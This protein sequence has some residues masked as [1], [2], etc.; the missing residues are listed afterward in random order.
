MQFIGVIFAIELQYFKKIIMKRILLLLVSVFSLG[1][2]FGQVYEHNFGSTAISAHPYNITPSSIATNLTG[3]S[4][5]NSTGSWTSYAGASGQAIS[6]GN[7]AGSPTVTLTFDVDP[8]FQLDLTSFDFWR[9]RSNSGAQNWS[10]AI[11]G[12]GVGSGSVPTSG[13]SIGVTSVT[14]FTGLTGTVTIV[15]SLSGASGSGTFRLDDFTLNGSVTSLS[16]DTELNFSSATYSES[17]NGTSVDLCVDITN[18]SVTPT[19]ANVVLTTANSPHLTAYT[20][21]G[22]TFP[23]SSSAQQCVTVSILDNT[24]CSDAT[25]YT[26]ELQSVSGGTNASAGSVDETILSVSDDDGSS[27]QIVFQGFETSGDTWNYTN[28]GGG[29]SSTNSGTPNNDRRK[30]GARSF[31]R[32][33]GAATITFDNGGSGVDIST[34]TNVVVDIWSAGISGN[35]SNGMDNNDDIEV[36]VSQTAT[37]G[38]TP[39]IT[40]DGTSNLKYGMS[41]TGV[42]STTAG[43]PISYNYPSGGTKSGNDAKS[44]LKVNIPDAWNT[45]FVKIVT[46]SNSSNEIWCI[47]DVKLTGDICLVA[48][49][50]INVKGNATDIAD[51]DVTPDAADD[52]DFG[53]VLITGGTNP[54][55]FTIQ[56]TGTAPLT[57]TSAVSSNNTDFALTAFTPGVVLAGNST[58]FTV[59]FD[60]TT[61]GAKTA[62]ITIASNDANENPYT[63]DIEGNA[64]DVPSIVLNSTAVPASNIQADAAVDNTVIYAFD[65]AVTNFDAEL[66]AFNF[67]TSGTYA[68]SNVTNFKTWYSTDANFNSGSDTQLDLVNTTLGTGTHAATGFSQNITN[69]S[70]GYFFIT[71][72]LPCDATNGNTIIVDAIMPADFTFSSGVATGSASASGTHT[73][74]EVAPNNVTALATANC[75]NGGV[76]VSWAAA[77]GCLDNYL[78]IA[79]PTALTTAPSTGPT[80]TANATYGSGTAYDDG[81]IVYEGSGTSVSIT[82]LTNGTNYTY[83]VFTRNGTS[84]SSGVEVDC[85]PTLVYCTVASWSASDSEIESVVLTGENNSINNVTTNTCTNTVQ[86][87]TAMSADLNQ[88]DTYTLSV[89]FG[90]CNDGTQYD[91]AGG[92]W[93][94]W[95]SNGSFNDAGEEI[96]TVD[97]S[98]S[99]GNVTEIFS[100]SVGSAQPIGTYTMRIVQDEGGA[101]GTIDPCVSPG[102]GTIVDYSV[103]VVIPCT[104]THAFTS[105]IPTSGPVETEITVTGSGF[106]AS[107]T[108]S[109]GATSAVVEF[110]DVNTLIVNV[111][112]GVST[113]VI[114]LTE[115]ACDI[116]T[117]TFTLLEENNCASGASETKVVAFQG[118]EFVSSAAWTFSVD[119]ENTTPTG[120]QNYEAHTNAVE[121]TYYNQG[122][123]GSSSATDRNSCAC[124]SETYNLGGSTLYD[125]GVNGSTNSGTVCRNF[126]GNQRGV[127]GTLAGPSANNPTTFVR[128]GANA[129]VQQSTNDG[130]D[131]AISKIYFDAIQIPDV[132]NATNIKVRVYVSSISTDGVINNGVESADFLR[133]AVAYGNSAT[134]VEIVPDLTDA[135]DWYFAYINGNID[136][137]SS[138]SGGTNQRWDYLGNEYNTSGV[139]SGTITKNLIEFTIPDNTPFVRLFIDML[140]DASDNRELWSVDDIQIIADYPTSSPVEVTSFTDDSDCFELDYTITADEGDIATLGDL[141][142]QWKYN[143]G[144]ST[145]WADVTTFANTIVAG[146]TGLNL[147]ISGAGLSAISNYQFYCEV[148]EASTCVNVSKAEKFSL[149]NDRY[150]RSAI[151]GNWDIASNWEMST[152]AAGPTWVVACTYPTA[153]NSDYISI[154]SGADMVLNID[155]TADQLIVQSGA[156]LTLEEKLIIENG[157]TSGEDLEVIGTLQDNGS[158]VNGLDFETGATWK[159]DAAG[160]IIKTYNSSVNKYKDN[161]ETGIANIPA[162]AHWAFVYDGSGSV[163]VASIDM[164]YPNLYFE[165][166]AGA[167]DAND[168]NEVFKGTSGFTTVK[169]NLEIGLSTISGGTDA[170]KVYNNNLNAQP[171]LIMG[172]VTIAAGSEFTN[173]DVS[174]GANN[175]TGIEVKGNFLIDGTLNMTAGMGITK[176]SGTVKQDVISASGTGLYNT[177]QFELDNTAHTEITDIDINITNQ[178]T[179]TNGKIITDVVNKPND[180]VFVQKNTTSAIVGGATS[181]VSNYVEGKLQ[182]T[183]DGASSYTFPVGHA[184]QNAQGFTIDV[185]GDDGANILAFLYANTGSD[186][187]SPLQTYAYCDVE[188]STAS[189]Q[190][191]GQGTAGQDGILDQIEFNI[192]SPLKW[193]ITN[194]SGGTINEYDVVVLANGGQDIN[195]VQAADGS[196]YMRY[197][198]KDGQAYESNGSAAGSTNGAPSFNATGFEACPNQYTLTGMTS[199]SSFTLNGA[200]ASGTALPVEMLYFEVENKAENVMLSWATVTEIN[201]DFFTIE[202][203]QNGIDFKEIGVEKGA[204]NYSGTLTYQFIDKQ[205]LSGISY[206]RLKQTDFDASF[207][208]TEIKS[209]NRNE[210]K[211]F[212]V[213][214]YPNP[215]SESLFVSTNSEIDSKTVLEIY[216]ITGRKV[217]E[218]KVNEFEQNSSVKIDVSKLLPGTYVVKF[219]AAKNQKMFNF[220]KK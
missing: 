195:P 4:W 40:I 133:A 20:T 157:N 57:L 128:N 77:T 162:S 25:D 11:N 145:T 98:V 135:A 65:L 172:D 52:T 113:G 111:P 159:L 214:I 179:F 67:V 28:S 10:M 47:D 79:S 50:E 16:T 92:V 110:I 216:D 64:T 100:I 1:I 125:N 38:A 72:D 188:T 130:G 6:L 139:V 101:S 109:F 151:A 36:Y 160:T 68:A 99:G 103:E 124:M 201:N 96:G 152:S 108:A 26:F 91:G 19:T 13:S 194:P 106:T 116:Q 191:V 178:L 141:T 94:D 59:T 148:T 190:Q 22:I 53:D 32:A 181:G 61:I 24:V 173:V 7:S 206:Y 200:N 184:S 71:V 134:D 156:K 161:Y 88:G 97:V 154:E 90:D 186:E 212:D 29:P 203:S 127:Y 89:E 169:G 174:A 210:Q 54:N 218:Q 123:V 219:N 132:S 93:I 80:Y 205:A 75:E 196:T 23:A 102:W 8:G 175:G 158:T 217:L 120:L 149:D 55:V 86:D 69:G 183:T 138:V 85:T 76:D 21:T 193:Q 18:P 165:S 208:Y 107:T 78:V 150:F 45:V 167:Y 70:T 84:W 30:S 114:T 105:M 155:L 74:T 87:N 136:A 2:G 62:T 166:S 58:T 39:D 163:S 176:F 41:G 142:Y 143:D 202:R 117:G 215:V 204:G 66:T 17:E 164:F 144:V 82:G 95:N 213:N 73:I 168:L 12:T 60:P 5:I 112:T 198:L 187:V 220:I 211:V 118:F 180:K 147:T 115:T 46:Q 131:G 129:Y 209:V 197:L 63:F 33:N 182:W 153:V 81:Y 83:T 27:G 43:T 192:A 44:N 119:N 171:M 189:G 31:Q 49:P 122:A 137:S 207:E 37:F 56:N 14:G 48:A 104:P 15:L 121:W 146:E 126:S 35:G 199:F 42:V 140:N 177:Y 185:T 3:S 34:A 9:R 51:G 170:Y